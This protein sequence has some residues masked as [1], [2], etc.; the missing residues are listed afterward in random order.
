[1]PLRGA[2]CVPGS[3]KLIR[4]FITCAE[5]VMKSILIAATVLLLVAISRFVSIAGFD[6]SHYSDVLRLYSYGQY[7]AGIFCLH[8][9]G[10]FVLGYTHLRQSQ[11]NTGAFSVAAGFLFIVSLLRYIVPIFLVA[12]IGDF[13]VLR[14]YRAEVGDKLSNDA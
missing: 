4:S 2:C 5:E 11:P 12:V 6:T 9:V 3:A 10:L 14:W 8:F 7:R 1:M 13:L